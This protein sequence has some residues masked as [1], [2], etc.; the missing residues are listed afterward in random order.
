[1][2]KYFNQPWNVHIYVLSGHSPVC[3]RTVPYSYLFVV[4]PHI[5][6]FLCFRLLLVLESW[7]LKWT[8]RVFF[9]FITACAIMFLPWGKAYD[10]SAFGAFYDRFISLSGWI[11]GRIIDVCITYLIHIYVQYIISKEL[12]RI[13]RLLLLCAQFIF[14]FGYCRLLCIGIWYSF[15]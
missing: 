4:F 12:L 10:T 14:I 2:G 3:F 5:F 15:S 13:V 7:I 9:L 6:K 8:W 1:M 11:S